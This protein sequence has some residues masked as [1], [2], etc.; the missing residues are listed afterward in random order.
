M[1]LKVNPGT[2]YHPQPLLCWPLSF[3]Y[4]L[5]F[6][7][8]EEAA[9]GKAAAW[10]DRS[11]CEVLP[12]RHRHAGQ[13]LKKILAT[14]LIGGVISIPTSE[15]FKRQNLREERRDIFLS[16]VG[17]SGGPGLK[18]NVRGKFL[19]NASFYEDGSDGQPAQQII[20]IRQGLALESP[21]Y[22]R[23]CAA[24]APAL[25]VAQ[26]CQK[27]KSIFWTFSEYFFKFLSF[28]IP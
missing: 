17:V 23:L 19:W 5:V 1:Q 22:S 20:I 15:Q 18:W 10:W 14:K 26:L 3:F 28:F 13:K 9:I 27:H 4:T 16:S 6:T 25:P 21:V 24:P 7:R 11:K 12:E 8:G 2:F